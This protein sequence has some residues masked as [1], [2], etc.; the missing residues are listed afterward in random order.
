M[1]I[2]TQLMTGACQ[3]QSSQNLQHKQGILVLIIL[4][5][6][7]FQML[8]LSNKSDSLLSLMW[9]WRERGADRHMANL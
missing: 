2:S 8:F 3:C 6:D 7:Y 1:K 5:I 9:P 4:L